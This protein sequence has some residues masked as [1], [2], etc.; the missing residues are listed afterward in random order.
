M[1]R[2]AEKSIINAYWPQISAEFTRIGLFPGDPVSLGFDRPFTKERF[3]HMLAELRAIPSGVGLVG[4]LSRQGI[5]LDEVLNEISSAP[6][7]NEEL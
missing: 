5:D 7:P 3:E 2:E 4:Y 1:D 6:P